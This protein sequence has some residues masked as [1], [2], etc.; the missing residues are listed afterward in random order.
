MFD[1]CMVRGQEAPKRFLGNWEVVLQTVGYVAYEKVGG[2]KLVHVVFWT[3]A[4]RK[5]V[6]AVKVNPMMRMPQ[7]W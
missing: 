2:S 7:R 4:R 6:E 1:F 5:F 3:L